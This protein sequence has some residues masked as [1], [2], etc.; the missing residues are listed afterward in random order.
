MS[1][2]TFFSC[3]SNLPL[4]LS[5]SLREEGEE[6]REERRRGKGEEREERRRGAGE[7]KEGGRKEQRE[8]KE[9]RGRNDSSNVTIGNILTKDSEHIA[10][11]ISYMILWSSLS[12]T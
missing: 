5:S 4:S 11:F 3:L 10:I 9:E 2:M 7:D 8:G 6:R 12:Q 1:V